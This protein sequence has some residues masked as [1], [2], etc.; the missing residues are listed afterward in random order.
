MRS[1][2]RLLAGVL[3]LVFSLAGT[4]AYGQGG[5]TGAI[6]GVV[7][8]TSGG[9]VA[10]AELQ[11]VDAS[12]EVVTRKLPTNADGAFT[13][14]L[15]PPGTY[16]ALVNKPGFAQARVDGIEVRITETTRVT[17]S[18]KPGAVTEKV[19]ISAQ[20]TTV[21]T[22]NAA[23]GQSID[24]G[25]V[26]GL[27]LAT[28]NFQQL[29][30][31]STGAQDRLNN[32]TQLGR[33][34]VRVF[35]NGQRE[36]NNNYQIEGISATDYN[37]AE[38]TNTPLPNPDVLQEFK[39]QTSLYDASQGRNGGGSVNAVLK[40]GTKDFHFDA[41]EF[42]RN[43]VLNANDFFLNRGGIN[44]PELKQNIF[45]VSGG[46]PIASKGKFG[47]FFGNYQG[48]RQRSGEDN[49]TII[50]AVI[51]VL[52]QDRSALNLSRT[53]FCNDT[54]QIDPVV[55]KLL[56]FKSNQ[57]GGA[58]GGFLIPSGIG[59]P[60]VGCVN[61]VPKTTPNTGPFVTSS[62]GR[63]T[64][65]QFTINW[66]R[67][68]N[69]QKDKVAARFFFTN[70]ESLKPFGAGGLTQS[71]N[72]II[73]KSDLNF[74]YDAPVSDR[75]FSLTETHLF[76]TSL[77][78][79]FRFGFVRINNSGINVPIVTASD[80]GIN[81]PV[82]NVT[83]AAYNFTF[84]SS[85]FK[86]GPTP[87]AD[88]FQIQNNANV[89][90]TFSW[91]HG[92]HNLRFGGDFSHVN[93][94]KL[95]P[96]IFNGQLFF[97]NSST[98]ATQTD[99]INFLLGAPA[100]N[101]GAGGA[102][103]HK[104]RI[105]NTAFFGQD[106]YKILPDLTLNLGLRVEING[107]FHD[108]LCHIGNVN[109]DLVAQGQNP[110]IFPSCVNSLNV[111]GLTGSASST[112]MKNNYAT[113]LG[114][115]IGFAYDVLGR[116][117]TTI[118]AGYGIYYVREDM[119][120]VDQLSFQAPILPVVF[121]PGAPGS[122]TNFYAPC[123]PSNPP[124]QNPACPNNPNATPPGGVISP[125]FVP[126]LSHITSFPNTS[127]APS[128][129]GNTINLFTLQIPQHFIVPQVQQWNMTV[130]RSLPLKWV[131]EVG[132]VGTHSIHLR[133]T[134]DSEQARLASAANPIM[135]NV[136][137]TQVPITTNTIDNA[138]A[139]ARTVG[140]NG[141]SG[142]EIFSNNAYS[143]YHSLQVTLSRRW[144]Q[145][146]FQSAYTFSKST[147]ATSTGNPAFNTAF[148][149]QTNLQDSRGPSDFDRPHRLAVSY[150]YNFPFFK[151]ATGFKAAALRDW[152]FTGV[153]IFQSG[154]PFSIVD[155]LAG[156]AFD[157]VTTITATADFAPGATH[158]SGLTSGS[159]ESRLNGYV[160]VSAFVPA[161]AIGPITAFGA[162]TAFGTLG[163]NIYR[164]PFE[165]NWDFSLVKIFHL[166]ERQ[167]LRFATDFFNVWNHP[168]FSNPAFT[169]VESPS[170]FGQ[171]ISTENNP[172]IMQFSLRWAF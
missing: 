89:T 3:A 142:F 6:S 28:Q 83:S 21:E 117:N 161:P 169:D 78:N 94:D 76:S 139:R 53:F 71:F 146:Y 107:A 16:Y 4:S 56:N 13:A 153:S 138:P 113:G 166:T 17:I 141:Y 43:D 9:S 35:V 45:G 48:S 160:N 65:D 134:R 97:A 85:G 10:S 36:D 47:Y 22:T 105:T 73:N 70:S 143:H 101:F 63:F 91:I 147:D 120:A 80:L 96:Q 154:T 136:A 92:K 151:N 103:N 38:L 145:G 125:A 172:R 46:G 20:V 66:D 40:S 118:R 158:A 102:Y 168:V 100:F 75:F 81:R 25:T 104:Y 128:F 34:D 170:N 72:G 129:D 114:P 67:E 98:P 59:T 27:P 37:V 99:F 112:T 62:T 108:D 95:F 61:G 137:G 7:V 86:I 127:S 132:Y 8:D 93:L 24:S 164:G 116:H 58:A 77:V 110:F 68:F 49:G 57:F 126:V 52:P 69:E 122:L 163:R 60:G 149:D 2:S 121:F 51:P 171:I 33:G 157:G 84:F 18:L 144:G 29:L 55:L 135:V 5:A 87:Q 133:V 41:Y 64:D 140:L 12:T 159:V 123:S 30:T 11:I 50:S 82:N 165:Q 42:F 156:Q 106:D 167:Q 74:P 79:E 54:T 155:S 90:D 44:R 148:N 109:P 162:P 130:Q 152:G 88:Q 26:R 131:L 124:P 39:V 19:E 31:L 15:L 111:P 14:T 115:R 119:G 1:I 150:V 32:A 23:T